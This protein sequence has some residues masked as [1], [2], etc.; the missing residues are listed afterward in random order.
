MNRIQLSINPDYSNLE[1]F[2]NTLCSRFGREGEGET[3][4]KGRNEIKVFEHGGLP[5]NVK[6]FR[7][8]HLANRI[9]YT[10]FRKPK[11]ERSF[12]YAGKLRQAGVGTPD[13]VA[14]I[15]EYKGGL[16]H[17]SYFV[18]LQMTGYE[19]MYNTGKT[20]FEANE[21]TL[22]AFARFTAEIHEKGI[23]HKDYSPGN[24]LFKE[25]KGKT[26][27]RL[28]DINRMEFGDVSI[29]KGCA[30]FARLWGKEDVFRCIAREYAAAR[31][32]DP[33]QCTQWVLHYRNRFWKRYALKMTIPFDYE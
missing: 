16:L 22:A 20:P 30:N 33:Q 4:H 29:R 5:V 18:S 24:I 11:A 3:I 28:V 27:F 6:R 9:A 31:K 8:P 1:P 19:M 2:V 7:I 17:Y 32:A 10:F 13:P 21:K 12:I 25:I 26:D 14:F 15:L 23:Y